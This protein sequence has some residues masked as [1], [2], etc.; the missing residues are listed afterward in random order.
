MSGDSDK[1]NRPLEKGMPAFP[2]VLIYALLPCLLA[3]GCGGNDAPPSPVL[4]SEIT[5]EAGLVEKQR[6][7]I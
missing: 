7:R 2:L 6:F 4:L 1:R 3:C 5:A